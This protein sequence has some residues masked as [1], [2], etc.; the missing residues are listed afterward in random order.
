MLH[1]DV[2]LRIHLDALGEVVMPLLILCV[3]VIVLLCSY[4]L[5]FS[6]VPAPAPDASVSSSVCTCVV[7]V[8]VRACVH[9]QG[10]CDIERGRAFCGTVNGQVHA[11]RGR[12]DKGQSVGTMF[13]TKILFPTA[14]IRKAESNN[15][16]IVLNRTWRGVMPRMYA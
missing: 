2:G 6:T 16:Y 7:R 9:M 12:S 11:K 15:C 1:C 3:R 14:L 13:S 4:V 5:F 8:H 10:E